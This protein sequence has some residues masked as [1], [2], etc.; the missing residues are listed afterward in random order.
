M[1]IQVSDLNKAMSSGYDFNLLEYN[2]EA[3]FR[4]VNVP[5]LMTAMNGVSFNPNESRAFVYDKKVKTVG[6]PNVKSYTENGKD[7][8]IDSA[9]QIAFSIPSFG[10]GYGVKVG[11]WENRRR[12]GGRPDEKMTEAD[13]TAEQTDKIQTAWDLH[14]ELGICQL[15]TDDTNLLANDGSASI[16]PQ[17]SMSTEINGS[18]RPAATALNLAA[19]TDAVAH[20]RT[21]TNLRRP[22]QQELGKIQK[23]ANGYICVCGDNFFDLAL[24]IEAQQNL[25]RDLRAPIDLASQA[26]M[27]VAAGGFTFDQFRGA[28]GILYVNYGSE[29]IGGTKLIGDDD[30]YLM[31]MGVEGMF[32][33]ELAPAA[34]RSTAGRPAQAMYQFDSSDDFGINVWTE[35]NRLYFNRHPQLI[36][37]LSALA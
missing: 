3:D 12:V 20:R 4:D 8:D 15:I 17:Y 37:A 24:Q 11:D 2:Q 28:D 31:P 21:M 22:L 32:N 25:N 34:R 18:A 29:I 27:E 33:V 1:T 13:V 30:A 9:S 14:T 36:T 35:S 6:L 16:F 19:V 5:G 26:A 7:Q 23:S 10:T